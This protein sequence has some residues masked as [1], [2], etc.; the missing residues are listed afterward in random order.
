MSILLE[1]L[2]NA[3]ALA[4]LLFLVSVGLSLVFGI[5]RVV[6]FAHGDLLHARRLPLLHD[7]RRC[8]EASGSRWSLVP[9]RR[10]DLRRAARELDA[11]LHL[12]APADLPAP[13]HLR[14]RPDARGGRA[15]RLRPHREAG[16]PAAR[17][18]RARSRSPDSPTRATGSSSS[19]SASPSGSASGSSSRRTR[20]GLVIRAVAQNSEMADCLGADV[21]RVR[22][23]VFGVA[24]ALAGLGGVAAAPMTSA[25]LGMGISV[26][27]DAFVVVVVGGLG[28][29]GG[30]MAG[31]LIVGA[32]QTWGGFYLPETAMVIMYA[33]MGAIL[34]FRP[35]GP[36]RRRGVTG[37]MTGVQRA[38]ALA[39]LVVL[40]ALPLRAGALPALDPDR[41]DDLR[42]LR[43][44]PRPH[45]G[46]HG[47]GLLRPRRLL[48]TRRVRQRAPPHHFAV[49]IPVALLAGALLAGAMALPIGYIST[50]ATGIYFAMLTLAFAQLL[51]TIAYKWR[52]LTGGSDG[53]AGVPK[54][55][56]LVGRAEPGLADR[57]LLPRRGESRASRC[58]SAAGSCDRRSAARFRP[59]AR[60]SGSSRCSA[61][62]RGGSSSAVFVIS[63]V[64]AGLAGALFAPF[65]GFASPEVMFW[66]LSGQ[67][68]MMVIIGGIGH[69]HRTGARGD[70]VHADPGGALAATP[71]SGCSSR[72]PSSC[73]WS[74]S[75]PADSSGAVRS[76]AQTGR[77]SARPQEPPQAERRADGAHPRDPRALAAPSAPS[78]P[79]PT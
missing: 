66:V 10:R 44:L 55:I 48:R 38:L 24:C 63:A 25:Y 16:G 58:S 56:A 78:A 57:V 54:T 18:S 27:V 31:S 59:F 74:S 79:W 34:I 64:F 33:V 69:A 15:A 76:L 46:L 4:A 6:N 26:I 30:S 12:P 7:G 49:P 13:P 68:L 40:G 39:A 77:A 5:L 67:A 43:A 72:E 45:H 61:R 28:S 70:G 9:P 8:R 50:R 71:S 17:C 73:S 41:A 32:A 14:A 35:I 1:Q 20:A 2:L 29:I 11:P 53:I 36:V 62:I 3:V 75:C 21:R 22:T 65:R 19:S 37:A 42:P 23:L 51:Y 52:D 60:T 47:H